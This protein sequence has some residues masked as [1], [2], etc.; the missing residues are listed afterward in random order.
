MTQHW[1]AILSL[2]SLLKGII[3]HEKVSFIINS[4]NYTGHDV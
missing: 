1:P 2:N 3:S 4:D